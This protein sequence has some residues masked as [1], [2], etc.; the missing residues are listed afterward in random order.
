MSASNGYSFTLQLLF[1]GKAKIKSR[2]LGMWLSNVH[3]CVI[4][5]ARMVAAVNKEEDGW[6]TKR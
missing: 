1:R 3:E 5:W 2:S 4:L 6:R